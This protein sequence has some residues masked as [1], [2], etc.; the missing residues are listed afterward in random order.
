[1][2]NNE[3]TTKYKVDISELVKGMQAA[4][5]QVALAN[6]EFKSATA[7]MDDWSKSADGINAKLTQLDKTLSNQKTIL[8]N[9]EEQYEL[10][11]KQM[12]EGSKEADNLKI[13]IENQKASIAKTEKEIRNYTSSLDEVV[14]AEKTAAKTGKTVAEVLDDTG[15]SAKDA[16]DGFTIFKGAVAT[17]AG[18]IASS[19]VGA[20]KDLAGNLLGLA[21]STREYRDQMNKLSSSGE[22][23]GYGADYAKEKYTDLYSVLGDETASSTAVS[24]FMAMNAEQS[25][26]DSLLN[27]SVGIWAK[28]GDSIPLDG[29]AESVNETAKVGAVTGNLADALNWAGISEDEFNSKLEKCTSEQERQRLIA[30]TL[31]STYGDLAG[32]YKENNSS[33]IEANKANASYTDTMAEFGAR[34]EP[35]TT[36]VKEGFNQLLQKMLELTGNAD[37][38]VVTTAIEGAFSVLINDVLPAVSSGLGWIIDNKDVVV[39]SLVAIGAGFLAFKVVTLIQGV[40]KAMQGM[41]IAQYA[42][43]LAMSLNPIGLIISLIAGLVAAFVVLWNKSEAF[44]NFFIGIWQ[45]ITSFVSSAVSSIG[46]F[47]SGLWSSITSVWSAASSWFNDNVITPIVSFFS[48]L[49]SAVS[50]FFSNLWS[51][52]V[53]VFS[54]AIQ[55]FTDLFMSVFN[56]YKSGFELVV[57]LAKGCW[58]MICRVFEVVAGWFDKNVIQPVVKFFTG[59]WNSITDGAKKSWALISGVFK[60]VAGWFDK[61]LIQ[62]VSNFFTGMWSKLTEGASQA[63]SGIKS[64]FSTV[65]KFFG[66]IFSEAWNKVKAVFSV[67]GKIFDGIKDGIVSAFKSVVNAI[68]RGINKVVSIP[69]NAINKALKTIRN[70]E[71]L[72]ISPFKGLLNEIS[73]PK[74]PELYEGGVLRK[75]QVGFLEG[76]G[77]E[78]VV[79]LEHNTGWLDG[80]ASRIVAK[81]GLAGA[82]SQTVN[83]NYNYEFNQTNNSPKP[84]SRLDIYR[85]T[86]NQL[87]LLKGV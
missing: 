72:G 50:G 22:E 35:I 8:S 75:G 76:N 85:Q 1:M 45:S 17:F 71:F 58:A 47:F 84:L 19:A 60:V 27:S 16:G 37:M 54:P 20:I 11:V 38:S 36:K 41:T 51:D 9:L 81:G 55:W 82:Q 73:V 49:W 13:K 32:A 87:A 29:L 31:N 23:A 63:W 39:A 67:G 3:T 70:I 46:E 10:T 59:L 74:I 66:D 26:L 44:R 4:K 5:R 80:V 79:P 21:E 56:F 62:P 40:S 14:A 65:A 34:V 64:V 15:D 61:N 52:I 42:L 68:I 69:F 6:A 57:G 28:Y 7:G 53:A 30:D 25:T 18:N 33:I 24:N 77:D 2:P 86:R 83:N 12:G 48:G 43:N 78:A